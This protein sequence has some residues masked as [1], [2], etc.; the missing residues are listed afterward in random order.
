MLEILLIV[1]GG[2][3]LFLFATNGLSQTIQKVAGKNA[4]RWLLIFTANTFSAIAVGTVTTILLDSSSAVIIITIALVNSKLLTLRQSMGIVLGA[5]IGTTVGSQIIALDI[6]MYSPVL[7][8]IGFILIMVSKSEKYTN[9]GSIIFYFGL[10]FFGLFIIGN[11]VE[12]LKQ[13]PYVVELLRK[14]ETPL[15]GAL[16]GAIVTAILQSSSATV[17]MVIVL[18]KN[19]LLGLS[20]ALA[21]VI[22]A[23]IGTCA[24]TLF[25]TING[26]R[27]AFKTGLFHLIFNLTFVILGLVFFYPL[28]HLVDYLGSNFPIERSIANAHVLFNLG[29]VLIF[30]WILPV[31]ERFLHKLLPEKNPTGK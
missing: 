25:A 26:S 17:G 21:I 15:N 29:A 10:L 12:P 11:A 8:T 14:T 28:V 18:A 24:D 19:G 16:A 7:L 31:F 27:E 23:E 13:I 6:G 3:M 22:G 1:L 4:K 20:G 9:T 2:L 30:V 5:N